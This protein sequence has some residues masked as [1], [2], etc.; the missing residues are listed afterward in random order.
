MRAQWE[1][2]L[3][4]IERESPKLRQASQTETDIAQERAKAWKPEVQRPAEQPQ[5][6]SFP[7]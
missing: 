5:E 4:R 6:R 3:N 1:K 2:V 7:E